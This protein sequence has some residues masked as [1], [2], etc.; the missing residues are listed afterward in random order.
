MLPIFIK[1]PKEEQDDVDN[2]GN[3]LIWGGFARQ[4][5]RCGKFGDLKTEYDPII[6]RRQRR[7]TITAQCDPKG[8]STADVF[9]R[10][11]ERSIRLPADYRLEWGGQHEDSETAQNM[12]FSRL[13]I[14]MILWR[15]LSSPCSTISASH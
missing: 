10:L 15:S 8:R 5:S 2:L 14:A 6:H 11:A 1:A 7:P 4:A 12:V 13:P 9:E 3:A